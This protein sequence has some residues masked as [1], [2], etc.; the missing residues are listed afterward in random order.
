MSL[1]VP[2]RALDLDLCVCAAELLLND[3]LH[4]VMLGTAPLSLPYVTS[5]SDSTAAN[6]HALR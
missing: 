4:M 2:Y 3:G 6:K 5:L 1:H